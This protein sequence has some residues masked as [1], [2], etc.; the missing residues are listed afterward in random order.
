MVYNLYSTHNKLSRIYETLYPYTTDEMASKYV[1]LALAHSNRDVN[2]Y[3]LERVATYNVETG[4]V[5]EAP[6]YFVPLSS[7]AKTDIPNSNPNVDDR[8][9]FVDKK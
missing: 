4:E 6:R 8:K 1:A 3:E 2:E 9:I 7:T 5:K